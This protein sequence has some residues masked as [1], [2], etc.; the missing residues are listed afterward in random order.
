[1]GLSL[2]EDIKSVSEFK[3]Q[4]RQVFTQ[5]HRT[6]RPVV[7]TVNGRPDIVLLDARM[8]AYFDAP[9]VQ[10][11]HDRF[12]GWLTQHTAQVIGR[13]DDPTYGLMEVYRV[14]R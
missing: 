12:Y 6:G 11:D 8:R 3:K 2:T 5:L 13:I 1:M 7:I 14:G 4:I 10:A 9:E